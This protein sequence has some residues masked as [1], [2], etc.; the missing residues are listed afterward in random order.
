MVNR[1]NAELGISPKVGVVT[2]V[3]RDGCVVVATML[4]GRISVGSELLVLGSSLCKRVAVE[5]IQMN[6]VDLNSVELAGDEELGLRLSA[7]VRIGSPLH[8]LAPS[9]ASAPIQLAIDEV[10]LRQES[11]LDEAPEDDGMESDDYP[12]EL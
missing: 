6:D 10:M 3:Y 8:Q 4:P 2:S 1:R 12:D 11:E 5:S 7:P 9:T